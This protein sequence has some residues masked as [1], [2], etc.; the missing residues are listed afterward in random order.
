MKYNTM[1]TAFSILGLGAIVNRMIYVS[2]YH[3]WRFPHGWRREF[4]EFFKILAMNT[5]YF[6]LIML[7]LAVIF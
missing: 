5:V 1:I 7:L 3:E 4:V 6:I 2:A